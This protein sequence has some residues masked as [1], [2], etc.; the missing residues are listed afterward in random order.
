LTQEQESKA[1]QDIGKLWLRYL[2]SYSS[3]F[4]NSVTAICNNYL[5]VSASSTSAKLVL[6]IWV[7]AL[8]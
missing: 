2:H 3:I 5:Y 4:G 8:R 1:L 7:S 6:I